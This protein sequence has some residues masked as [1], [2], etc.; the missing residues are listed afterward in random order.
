MDDLDLPTI[1]MEQSQS[2]SDDTPLGP[3]PYEPLVITNDDEGNPLPATDTLA[4]TPLSITND[5]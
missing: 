3:L 5:D 2:I 4:S 1:T